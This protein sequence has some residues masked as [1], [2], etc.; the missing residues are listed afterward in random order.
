M[1]HAAILLSKR[2]YPLLYSSTCKTTC[3]E[4]T[5]SVGPITTTL[6]HEKATTQ[7]AQEGGLR[8]SEHDEQDVCEHHVGHHPARTQSLQAV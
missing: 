6:E 1:V 3:H 4:M 5:H 2:T 7:A 8:G